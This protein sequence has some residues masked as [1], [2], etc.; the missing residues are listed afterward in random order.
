MNKNS[1]VYE[2]EKLT[3]VS[4][5]NI[6]VYESAID[7]V[8]DNDDI[9]NV[10]ISGSY[11]SGK[12]SIVESYK[13]KH[14]D[15]KFMHISLAHFDSLQ[16]DE[17]TEDKSIKLEG[18]IIN[19]LVQQI[20][21]RKIP[22]SRFSQKRKNKTRSIISYSIGTIALL[23]SL[24]HNLFFLDWRSYVQ[25]L[26][27]QLLHR[28]LD[29]TITDISL[30]GFGGLAAIIGGCFIIAI[31]RLQ[32]NKHILSKIN[33]QG[34]EFEILQDSQD[35]YF[36]KYLNEVLYLFEKSGVDAIV[37]EDLD[38]NKVDCIFERLREI[39]RLVNC[40]TAEN[41]TWFS[42]IT[43]KVKTLMNKKEKK[44]LRFFY[45]LR[46]DLFVSKERTK[47]FD[48]IIPVVPVI[49][50]SNSY[51]QFKELLDS[52]M[53]SHKVERS[54]LKDI[55][56]YV[57][58][59][60]V[61]KN[62]YNEFVIY[63]NKIDTTEL[64]H[65]KMLAMVVYKNLFPNDF[66]NLQLN[67]GFVHAL[68]ANKE[69]LTK[70]EQ[71]NLKS[72]INELKQ[73]IQNIK[74]EF[75]DS[76]EQLD[77]VH[78]AKKDSLRYIY[79]TERQAKS[80]DITAWYDERKEAIENRQNNSE[81]SFQDEIT[82]LEK[83][84]SL[85]PSKTL[86]Q[87]ITSEN[88]DNVFGS[89]EICDKE[90]NSINTNPYFDLLK[91]LI[92]EGYIAEDYSDYMSY[93]DSSSVNT[94]DKMFLRSITDKKAK[95]PNYPIKNF[96]LVFESLN[97]IKFQQ[98]EILN[99]SLLNWM[100]QND[101]KSQVAE[102]LD[103]L[104]VQLKENK[105]HKFV[106]G[107]YTNGKEAS[108]F[109]KWLNNS[110]EGFVKTAIK[111]SW[112]T[113]EQLHQFSVDCLYYTENI[114]GIDEDN[115]LSNYISETENYL[116]IENPD[117]DKI[118]SA[119]SKLNIC[120]KKINYDVSNKEL[121]GVIYTGEYYQ[122]NF[123]NISLML[124]TQ[125]AV[126]DIEGIKHKNYTLINEHPDSPLAK[127]AKEN[128]NEYLIATLSNCESNINDS[129]ENVLELLNDSRINNA[130][131]LDYISLLTTSIARI[132][133]VKDVTLWTPLIKRGL[134]D[135][136]SDNI[137]EYHI[138]YGLDDEIITFIN[139]NKTTL[140]F[141]SVKQ[142]YDEGVAAKLFDDIA[143]CNSLNN[144]FYRDSLNSFNYIFDTFDETNISDDKMKILIK[145]HIL[146][147]G[148]KSL[149]YVR[150]HY[151][152]HLY[153]FITENIDKYISTIEGELFK[154]DEAVHILDL[155]LPEDKKLRIL[156]LAEDPIS[157]ANKNYS[158]NISAYLIE[159]NFDVDDIPHLYSHYSNYGKLTK[160][161]IRDYAIDNHTDIVKEEYQIDDSLLSELLLSDDISDTSKAKLLAI[162]M[163][164][165]SRDSFNKHLEEMGLPELMSIFTQ[166]G[167]RKK[168]PKTA[169][170]TILL[171]AMVDN[172]LIKAFKDDEINPEK[173]V[174]TKK[175][176][177]KGTKITN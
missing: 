73:K 112:L 70:D 57:D 29:W 129:Q 144:G 61:L 47:F 2:F 131:K 1:K 24:L 15:R 59:M 22:R 146:S 141:A 92:R 77:I 3:P 82:I 81:Q 115:V 83:E 80:A 68:F 72:R 25:S 125:C 65:N 62:I 26:D 132:S 67:K 10:A 52:K 163:P 11:G 6:D 122:I 74:K 13:K 110:W 38:R 177:K 166:Y 87:L 119:F 79:G 114:S 9:K 44:P 78:A 75:L 93:Y 151:P 168:Y 76:V 154:Q 116:S 145:E 157:I 99:Y 53:P 172:L 4:N 94:N 14:T 150:E 152:N 40:S 66:S 108:K 113:D 51:G 104:F 7:F 36:D 107:Y 50:S 134:V 124:R 58:D 126:D 174:I 16:T 39:N 130:L 5:S 54:F 162:A 170:V 133:N 64:N 140:D 60:R 8:F 138:E 100:L 137:T 34:N 43:A 48:V 105:N 85:L 12:S 128:I 31:I 167:S 49:D 175:D 155:T 84:M 120:F 32:I 160:K 90:T 139:Q 55:S 101:D 45:L 147:M 69:S 148:D 42:K 18:K 30:L 118:I 21:A 173:Y 121:F 89:C 96:E 143:S 159:N 142:D 91:Y 165:L 161:L 109:I 135:Y 156:S 17:S 123:D 20:P 27:S 37:F 153:I 98:K 56:L 28:A 102:C 111:S 103:T 117:I 41:E 176:S 106:L 164:T 88:V 136:T 158:D 23:L 86:S 97:P 33:I 149:N 19:Q 95:E 35:S 71:E 169:P 63:L 127:Y 46:D 171:E